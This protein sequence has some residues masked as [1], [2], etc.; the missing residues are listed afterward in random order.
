MCLVLMKLRPEHP[1]LYALAPGARKTP[2]L[3]FHH[4]ETNAIRVRYGKTSAS[5]VTM[6]DKSM[7]TPLLFFLHYANKRAHIAYYNSN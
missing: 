3:Q 6:S 5:S 1:T 2:S 7:Q 4:S